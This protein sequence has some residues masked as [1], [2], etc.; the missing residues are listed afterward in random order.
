MRRQGP[1]VFGVTAR[2][3]RA[4]RNRAAFNMFLVASVTFPVAA[5]WGEDPA[6]PYR[7]LVALVALSVLLVTVSDLSGAYRRALA[8]VVSEQRVL[9]AI[10]DSTA[11]V[12][13]NGAR[14][15]SRAGDIDHVVLGPMAAVVET[16]TGDGVVAVQG[17]LL[18]CNTR[19]LRGA[20]LRKVRSQARAVSETLDVPVT[21]VVCV[22]DMS[23]GPLEAGGVIVC[24]VADLLGVLDALGGEL[25][26]DEALAAGRALAEGTGSR[27]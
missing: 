10:R 8:G 21:P 9:A 11:G 27:R 26:D 4:L 14:P 20:S 19:P 2:Y 3:A 18:R 7:A 6:Q 16:K 13:V 25:S 12:V 23:N 15:D 5:W 17:D 1:V 24:S 22:V